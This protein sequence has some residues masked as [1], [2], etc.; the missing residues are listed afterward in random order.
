MSVR[1]DR[2]VRA[3]LRF[4]PIAET[5]HDTLAWWTTVPDARRAAPKFTITPEQEA[6]ALAAWKTRG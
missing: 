2:A 3:G 4:R 1:N 6:R 5:A